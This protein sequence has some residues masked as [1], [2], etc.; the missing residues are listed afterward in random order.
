MRNIFVGALVCLGLFSCG[1][2]NVVEDRSV[3]SFE[4]EWSSGCQSSGPN[5]VKNVI[6]V[7][8]NK[9]QWAR[10]GYVG[11]D[12]QTAFDEFKVNWTFESAK[13]KS[14]DGKVEI[15]LFLEG[16]YFKPRSE[17]AAKQFRENKLCR[18]EDWK[19]GE[20]KEFTGRNCGNGQGYAGKGSATYTI[21]QIKEEKLYLGRSSDGKNGTS[22]EKRHHEVSEELAYTRVRDIRVASLVTNSI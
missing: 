14:G 1:K 2:D 17:G 10:K 18:I 19:V 7:I 20:E 6:T 8:G 5:S 16:V 21:F 4:G 3:P 9:V 12:C 11:F 22:K 13:E 15:D